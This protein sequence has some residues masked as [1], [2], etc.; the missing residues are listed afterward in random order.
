MFSENLVKLRKITGM[1]QEE[2]AEKVG[3]SRQALSKWELGETV[4]DIEKSR[5]IAAVFG[6]TLDDLVNYESEDN[7]GLSV[8]PKGKHL[9]GIVTVG[10][11]GQIVIPAS[12][13]KLFN[14]Q[15]GD[16]FV[17]LGDETQGIALMKAEGF[18]EMAKMIQNNLKDNQG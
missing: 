4:P 10:D 12:A 6:V 18:L 11:K 17:A 13:R 14:I 9:F 16:R 15:P 1:T 7:L 2:L 3:V 8:P 5:D